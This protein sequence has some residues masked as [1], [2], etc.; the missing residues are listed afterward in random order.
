MQCPSACRVSRSSPSCMTI[1]ILSCLQSA[2]QTTS[3]GSPSACSCQ[4]RS[5]VLP[6]PPEAYFTTV[7][8]KPRGVGGVCAAHT[9]GGIQT[10]R[11]TRTCFVVHVS[12]ITYVDGGSQGQNASSV[13]HE[14]ASEARASR[15]DRQHHA[16]QARDAKA[17]PTMRASSAADR[18]A[19]AS[20]TTP[21]ARVRPGM[22]ART[23]ESKGARAWSKKSAPCVSDLA[24]AYPS[25]SGCQPG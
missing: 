18:H 1:H 12:T 19:C 14:R 7:P 8:R 9:Y 2:L 24:W 21:P 20:H 16:P 25:A 13:R 4:R 22:G 23:L 5:A 11:P 3:A 17:L 6:V 10:R 15:G